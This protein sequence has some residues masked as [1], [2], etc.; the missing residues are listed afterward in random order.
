MSTATKKLRQ[1]LT[2]G[3][4]VA[5]FV[6]DGLTAKI[7]ENHGFPAVYMTGHG[8]AA[9]AGYPDFGLISFKEMLTN[10]S[11]IAA[12]VD[13]PVIADADTGYGNALNAGRTVREYGRAGAAALHMEDQSFPKKCGF[14]EGKQVIPI[15]EYIGKLKAALD[16]RV[17]DDFVIIARTDALAVAGWDEVE[18]RA[19]RYRETGADLVFVDGIKTMDD[20]EQYSKR[21][22]GAGIPCLYNGSLAPTPEIKSRGFSVMITGG[23]HGLSYM[24]VKTAMLEIQNGT[25]SY[26]ERSRLDFNSI[27]DL[28]GLPEIYRL[29]KTYGRPNSFSTAEPALRS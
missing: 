8:T 6:Y 26:G 10:L 4:V 16:A 1:A 15:D 19:H 21:L 17:D 13:V 14:F 2:E 5:P 25:Y 29:E 3:L 11:Y 9:Q 27:T 28:L 12:A 23:G 20:L 18:T 22:V 7:A 24:A